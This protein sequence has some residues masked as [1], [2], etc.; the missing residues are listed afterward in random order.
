M[1]SLEYEKIYEYYGDR[2]ANRS[3]VRLMDHVEQGT[4]LLQTMGAG[5]DR[6]SA[7]Y[8]HPIFQDA[9]AY[10]A[11]VPQGHDPWVLMLATDYRY[12]ANAY[13]PKHP[14]QIP[15]ASELWRVNQMLI[16]DKVHNRWQFE[17]YLRGKIPNS[18]R[19]DEYFAQWLTALTVNENQYNE[20]IRVWE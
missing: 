11:F 14:S 9:E 16:A 15:Q 12:V 6:I 8:L 3:G 17:K 13:L 19:L 5:R 1:Y 18:D 20:Y 4:R 10:A 7:F 2:R